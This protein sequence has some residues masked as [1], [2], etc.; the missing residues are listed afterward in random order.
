[1]Q[2]TLIFD[3]S[4]IRAGG[5]AGS[6]HIENLQLF[7]Q[8]SSGTAWLDTYRG[9]SGVTISNVPAI[10]AFRATP[11]NGL[12]PLA[13]TFT[14]ASTGS[15]TNRFWDFGDGTTTNIVE[16]SIAHT[17]FSQGIYTVSL[18][19]SGPLDSSTNSQPNYITITAT[20]FPFTYTTTNGT[21]AITAYIG[22]G[23][24]VTIPSTLNS[25]PVTSIGDWAFAFCSSLTNV[26]IGTNVTSIGE[27][28]FAFCSS[29]TSVAIPDSVTSIEEG[30]FASCSSLTNVT[31]PDNVT[32]IGEGAFYDCIGLTG[33]YF[34]GNAPSADSSAFVA[35]KNATVYY[36][37]G[38]K[39]WDQW[40]NPPPAVLW[41]PLV[42]NPG[43]R[44]NQF[45]FNINWASG[46]VIVVEGCTNL[47]S[48]IWSPLQTNTLSADSLYFSDSQWTNDT[49]RFYRLRWP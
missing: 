5:G 18:I 19:V 7:E 41:K 49:R 44:T 38:T 27:G 39:G 23:G 22:S 16:T 3:L 35:D 1:M 13:V 30:A 6:Y 47:S 32:S 28:A 48:H 45:G 14:D 21:I 37:P 42:Q 12:A 25:L 40:V 11:T 43:V 29:L 17:Y 26:T 34:K 46:M 31:I 36:L 15:I 24:A 9:T 10:A 20:I 4:A 8:T 33:V 2:A